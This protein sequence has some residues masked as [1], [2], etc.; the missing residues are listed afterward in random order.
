MSPRHDTVQP[1]RGEKAVSS[2]EITIV[3]LHDNNKR[4]NVTP[5]LEQIVGWHASRMEHRNLL[6]LREL[7]FGPVPKLLC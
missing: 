5:K 2:F 3:S 7:F 6:M 1:T 4:N